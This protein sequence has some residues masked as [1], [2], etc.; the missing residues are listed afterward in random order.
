M[1]PVAPPVPTP[2]RGRHCPE[3]ILNVHLDWDSALYAACWLLD[4]CG[5]DSSW[6]C[7]CCDWFD[8]YV[9]YVVED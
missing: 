4:L 5:F 1:A 7:T 6:H 2:M 8:T 9:S 3:W